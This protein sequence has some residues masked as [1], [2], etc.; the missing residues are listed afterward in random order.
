M[1]LAELGREA[2]NVVGEK[3]GVSV[4]VGDLNCHV[5]EEQEAQQTKGVRWGDPLP[6]HQPVG[7]HADT[8]G[9][10]IKSLRET[11]TMIANGRFGGGVQYTQ[12]AVRDNKVTLSLLDLFIVP[13]SEWDRV[14]DCAVLEGSRARSKSDH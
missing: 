14:E 6:G 4:L 7:E 5:G 3:G 1:K 2:A 9:R 10:L 13:C 8:G 11:K 12:T